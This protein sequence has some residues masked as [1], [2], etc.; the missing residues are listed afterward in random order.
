MTGG[1]EGDV[2]ERDF[3]ASDAAL[4]APEAEYELAKQ[5]CVDQLGFVAVCAACPLLRM[6]GEC[7][8][9]IRENEFRADEPDS[10]YESPDLL[11]AAVTLPD[12]ADALTSDPDQV[13]TL[14]EDKSERVADDARLIEFKPLP[15]VRPSV[16]RKN[17]QKRDRRERRNMAPPAPVQGKPVEKGVHTASHFR[18][19]LFDD[20]IPLVTSFSSQP[21]APKGVKWG[22]VDIQ[23]VVLDEPPVHERSPT[24]SEPAPTPLEHSMQPVVEVDTPPLSRIDVPLPE[25]PEYVE[26][27][28]EGVAISPIAL[29][30]PAVND[31][32]NESVVDVIDDADA[33]AAA[34]DGAP[35][36]HNSEAPLVPIR[37]T[38]PSKH[39]NDTP[40]EADTRRDDPVR[41][42][43][44]LFD[45][46]TITPI[47]PDE[48]VPDQKREEGPLVVEPREREVP[49]SA[50]AL[51]SAREVF[52][53][54]ELEETTDVAFVTPERLTHYIQ[55]GAGVR[56]VVPHAPLG[57]FALLLLVKRPA[58]Q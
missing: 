43:D 32:T 29:N 15:K 17:E 38:E 8:K 9:E 25:A 21:E 47:E 10:A 33:V 37:H 27:A 53:V 20:S 18:A 42:L 5:P 1:Y 35:M 26:P 49:P 40:T 14:S 45:T 39:V 58:A 34:D 56:T 48:D 30:L 12:S 16:G 4:E 55:K 57:F 50:A 22:S 41:P 2:F 23:E 13:E 19:L 24:Y 11:E 52:S 31:V 28:V 36:E 3:E 7:P 51:A 54:D 46:V 44:A 6:F